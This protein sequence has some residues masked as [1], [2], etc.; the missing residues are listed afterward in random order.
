MSVVTLK[1]PGFLFL[2]ELLRGKVH[3]C[4]DK[5]WSFYCHGLSALKSNIR[6]PVQDAMRTLTLPCFPEEASFQLFCISKRYLT[7]S[8][9][10]MRPAS[11]ERKIS[12]KK[13][14]EI[15][16]LVVPTRCLI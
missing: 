9:G 8:S 14:S 10:M 6:S 1:N 15:R 2:L 7:N 12:L 16:T 13:R 4:R 3:G 11:A 5:R